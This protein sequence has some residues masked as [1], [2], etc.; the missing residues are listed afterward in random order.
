MDIHGS[1]LV[2]FIHIH[3]PLQNNTDLPV[4]GEGQDPWGSSQVIMVSE[5]WTKWYGVTVVDIS[6]LGNELKLQSLLPVD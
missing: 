6:L 4:N 1:G 3:N 2:M 5:R